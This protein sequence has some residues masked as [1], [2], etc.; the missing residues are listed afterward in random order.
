MGL[1]DDDR[2]YLKDAPHLKAKN[3]R[4]EEIASVDG[5]LDSG[6]HVATVS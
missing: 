6:V 5:K 4:T 3:Q 2:Y 1:T